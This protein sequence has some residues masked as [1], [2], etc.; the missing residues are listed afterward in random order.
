MSDRWS[1]ASVVVGRGFVGNVLP[2]CL[3]PLVNE[4]GVLLV[5]RPVHHLLTAF[6][7]DGAHSSATERPSMPASSVCQPDFVFGR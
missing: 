1:P 7:G 4:L 5:T 6:S 3:S 2:E